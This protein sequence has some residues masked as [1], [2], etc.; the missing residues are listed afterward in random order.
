MEIHISVLDR[1][2][3]AHFG[4]L[5]P[6]GILDL[7]IRKPGDCI[8]LGAAADGEPCGA[9]V[10]APGADGVRLT[11]VFVAPFF[12]GR[13]I[14]SKL[15][16]RLVIG[17]PGM[18]GAKLSWLFTQSAK[19]QNRDPWLN[20]F[21]E[22]GFRIFA[23]GGLFKTT[24]GALGDLPFWR[25]GLGG[26]DD[27]RHESVLPFSGLNAEALREFNERTAHALD[28]SALPYNE[29][30]ALP[31]ISHVFIS[32]GRIKGI[33]AVTGGPDL[34]RLSWLYSESVY[35][36][37]LPDLLRTVY[38]AAA[39]DCASDT[40]VHIAA[41]SEASRKLCEKLCPPD[42][43]RPSFRVEADIGTLR[44]RA[45]ARAA[46]DR[47]SDIGGIPWWDGFGDGRRSV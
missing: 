34:L 14:C 29:G 35:A 10:A 2:T 42:S 16:D 23:S 24:L 30:D 12:R 36:K 9:L 1:E 6:S 8:V 38:G 40:A 7:A 22:K 19:D 46:L 44:A 18:P 45:Q 33:A 17:L 25:Q 4:S 39:A 43:F 11:H 28:L 3:F 20:R 37:H 32:D 47:L 26:R 27:G 41:V 13:G 15:L 21:S 31:G 5:M